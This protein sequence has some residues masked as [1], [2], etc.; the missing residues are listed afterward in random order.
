ML[1]FK[2]DKE[3]FEALDSGFKELYEQKGDIYQLKV[4]GI[5]QGEDVTGLKAKVA[6]LMSE[7]KAEREKRQALE[8]AQQEAEEQR[9]KEKGEFKALYEKTLS[10][11]E[12]ERGEA[13]K[14]KQAIQQK[15]ME[16]L[17]RSI[18]ANL[19]TD[20]KRAKILTREAMP[21]I[22]FGENGAYIEKGGIAIEKEKLVN[23]LREEYPFLVDASTG[24]G[25]GASGGNVGGGAEG[26][27]P[28]KR[29]EGF[30]LT[31][32]AKIFEQDP[33]RALALKAAA[34]GK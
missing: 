12:K 1:K 10:E 29:G 23:Q 30:S 11:L 5:P 4:E 2:I 34:K 22:K 17:A 28:F 33:A 32:Q 27:N 19:T 15:E 31:E 21:F 6:E 25:G 26:Q 9:Q 3:A 8:K 13:A 14:F 24:R 16:A 7:T 18:A 20:E